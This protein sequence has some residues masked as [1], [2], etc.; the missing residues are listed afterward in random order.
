MVKLSE[1]RFEEVLCQSKSMICQKHSQRT[2]SRR[3]PQKLA[4]ALPLK[5]VILPQG[6]KGE[7]LDL[8][9]VNLKGQ[10]LPLSS[11]AIHSPT[12]MPVTDEF[13]LMVFE[14]AHASLLHHSLTQRLL[15]T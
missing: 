4:L 6:C 11:F 2:G 8:F 14:T 12:I 9:D 15:P 7:G 1:L 5:S 3:L 13:L 10:R